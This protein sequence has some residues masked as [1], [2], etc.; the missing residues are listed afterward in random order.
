MSEAF[1]QGL[2]NLVPRYEHEP[3]RW[4]EV[5]R[6]ASASRS[7]RRRGLALAIAAGL[8]A[9]ALGAGG[10]FHREF[11]DFFSAEPAPEPIRLD[12]AKMGARADLIMGPGHET[13]EAREVVK[14][15]VDGKLR[16]LWVAPM[17]NGGFCYRWHT[18]GSC[19]RMP[20]QGD[21]VKLGL[22]GQ[23]GPYG[24]NWIVG[25]VTD[26][27]IQRLELEYA[28]GARIE[29]RYV[30]V[31]SPIDAGF[32]AFQV[33]QERQREGRH[34]V[35]VIGFDANGKEI[36]RRALPGPTDPRWEAGAD[37][38]PRI[39]DRSKKRTLFDFRD[40]LGER[41]TLVVAPAP[42]QKLCYAHDRGGG[43]VSPKFPAIP[44]SVQGGGKTVIVCCTVAES[45]REVELLFQDGDR[46]EVE[47]V[48]GFLLYAVPS[49]HHPQ[50]KR[51]EAIVSR[52]ASGR[53]VERVKVK[54]DNPGVYPCKKSEEL[55]FGYGQTICP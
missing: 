33:P 55:E 48:D 43:C 32:T 13:H 23:E 4:D 18:F 53:E 15:P 39:A 35:A 6:R 11:V 25:H 36:E 46:I 28:D 9:V 21:A 42:D 50:G 51:L 20:H 24:Q 49:G 5:L 17:E 8:T 31:S 22:G 12:F 19:G 3:R 29:L 27:A 7:R 1:E 41:W 2:E 37:G 10:A 47:P 52:D 34:A 26:P 44:L 16:P 14:F 40:E 38:L 54:A 30:W 45:V